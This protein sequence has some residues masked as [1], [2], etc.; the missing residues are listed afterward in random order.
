MEVVNYKKVR[1]IKHEDVEMS[2]VN[3]VLRLGELIIPEQRFFEECNDNITVIM[4][5]CSNIIDR[6]KFKEV[7]NLE[8]N[9]SDYDY[10][11]FTNGVM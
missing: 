7:F 1:F 8:L 9:V 5:K 11:M 4:V 10:I 6:D 2:F 3:I